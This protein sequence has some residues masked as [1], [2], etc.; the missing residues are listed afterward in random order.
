VKCNR[1]I[2]LLASWVLVI[3]LGAPAF[4]GIVLTCEPIE[5]E[6]NAMRGGSPTVP[7]E[8]T[9]DITA[10]AR[11]V[12]GTAPADATVTDTTLTITAY[13]ALDDSFVDMK[14]STG[15]TLIVGRGGEGDKLSMQMPSCDTGEEFYFVSDFVGTSSLNGAECDSGPSTRLYKTCK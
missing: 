8:G 2:V 15:L 13:R 14:Q 4:A 3:G 6:I 11:I 5:I 10:K 9:K 7:S 1:V 12:T